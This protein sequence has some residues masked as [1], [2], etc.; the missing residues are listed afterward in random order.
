M[1]VTTQS[2]HNL[3]TALIKVQVL[4]KAHKLQRHSDVNFYSGF[5]T[6]KLGDFGKIMKLSE[7]CY[8]CKIRRKSCLVLVQRFSE[9]QYRQL[10]AWWLVHRKH[11]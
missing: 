3:R 10:R 1:N 5:A 4:W 9:S 8:I 7:V 11:S 2:F 6:Y